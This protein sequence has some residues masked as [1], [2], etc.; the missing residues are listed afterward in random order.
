[1]WY[2]GSDD[3]GGTERRRKGREDD[4]FFFDLKIFGCL[5]QLRDEASLVYV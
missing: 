2:G 4:V 1:M 3:G 5:C